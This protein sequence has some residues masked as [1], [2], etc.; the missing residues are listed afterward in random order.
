MDLNFKRHNRCKYTNVI[1][2]DY[3]AVKL[4]AYGQVTRL[5]AFREERL[6]LDCDY[7]DRYPLTENI[8]IKDAS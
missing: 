6:W 3:E 5:G 2:Y 8:C 7:S 4:F 1:L